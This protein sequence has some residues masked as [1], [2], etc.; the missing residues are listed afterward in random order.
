MS[1][2]KRVLITAGKIGLQVGLPAL[3]TF[4]PASRPIV[5]RVIEAT[6]HHD[7]KFDARSFIKAALPI[8]A[9]EVKDVPPF[10]PEQLTIISAL[11][12]AALEMDISKT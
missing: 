2:W 3:E 11:I 5:E 1:W 7:E 6:K 8:V 10:S 4:V 12:Q 9:E